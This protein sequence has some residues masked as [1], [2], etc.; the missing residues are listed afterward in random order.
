M[1]G[2]SGQSFIPSNI[3]HVDDRK[4][5]PPAHGLSQA[6]W[7]YPEKSTTETSRGLFG[8]IIFSF[9][10]SNLSPRR[11]G[12]T[13]KETYAKLV[14]VHGDQALSMKLVFDWFS[15]FRE[16]WESVFDETRNGR[17]ATSVRDENIEKVSKLITKDHRL[18]LR[19]IAG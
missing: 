7:K 3:G 9:H 17:P 15:R 10:Q 19:M 1:E 11:L 14:H 18:T 2:I 8:D 12:K 5:I 6:S 4:M 13:S 16:D